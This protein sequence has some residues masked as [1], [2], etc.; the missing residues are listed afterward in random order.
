MGWI[1]INLS[2]FHKFI[3]IEFIRAL[4]D[5][6]SHHLV[7]LICTVKWIHK[8]IHWLVPWPLGKLGAWYPYL[9]LA[10]Y[11]LLLLWLI[12]GTVAVDG[13]ILRNWVCRHWTGPVLDLL[14]GN[15]LLLY[16]A[17]LCRYST[18]LPWLVAVV[19]HL[20][21]FKFI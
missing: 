17:P 1:L 9:R 15:L 3:I 2:W 6:L 20:N 7:L 18:L 16:I 10:T 4:L 19:I 5:L 11:I 8:I 13:H 21:T 14:F 12:S